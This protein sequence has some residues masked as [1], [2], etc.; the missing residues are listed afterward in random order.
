MKPVV[1]LSQLTSETKAQINVS[2]YHISYYLREIS[3]GNLVNTTEP[4]TF[5]IGDHSAWGFYGQY[6]IGVYWGLGWFGGTGFIPYIAGQC[7]NYQVSQI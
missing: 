1:H 3:H 6:D 7:L 2:S 5:G 4:G